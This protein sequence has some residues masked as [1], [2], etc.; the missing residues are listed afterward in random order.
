MASC[1]VWWNSDL[2]KCAL[3]IV[4]VLLLGLLDSSMSALSWRIRRCTDV[5]LDPFMRSHRG[6]IS[7]FLQF[8]NQC[9]LIIRQEMN[10]HHHATRGLAKPT[11]DAMLSSWILK[12]VWCH[13]WST[14]DEVTWPYVPLKV[15]ALCWMPGMKQCCIFWD[16]GGEQSPPISAVSLLEVYF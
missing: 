10:R 5:G 2:T 7:Y 9:T 8:Q 16:G 13:P 6:K 14:S 11:S 4:F 15:V 3:S 1:G 12:N